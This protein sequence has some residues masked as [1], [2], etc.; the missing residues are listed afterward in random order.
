M[1][2]RDRFEIDRLEPYWRN[3]TVWWSGRSLREQILLGALAAIAIFALLLLLLSPVRDAR[4]DALADIHG[5]ALLEARLRQGG[6]ATSFARVRTGA[7]VAII[8]E[9]AAT[10]QLTLTQ[11]GDQGGN[12]QVKFADAAFDKVVNL[13]ADVERTSSLRLRDADITG[14]GATGLV[15]A[16]LVFGQ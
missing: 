5:A 7:G 8:T 10:A 9:S 3:V 4:D 14:Q 2:L 11:I 6:D 16:D 15:T 1:T 12:V 13:I